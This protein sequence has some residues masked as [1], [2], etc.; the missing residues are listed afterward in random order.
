MAAGIADARGPKDPRRK[1]A[2][3][4]DSMYWL[5]D[6]AALTLVVIRK[7]AVFFC[8]VICTLQ[9]LTSAAAGVALAWA[10]IESVTPSDI[11]MRAQYTNSFFHACEMT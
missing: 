6:T 8:G 3:R 7:S 4:V 9:P 1:G 10:H 11:A 5:P 2:D